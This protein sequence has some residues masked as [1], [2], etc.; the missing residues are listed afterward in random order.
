[1]S[2]LCILSLSI[3]ESRF[4]KQKD[5]VFIYRVEFAGKYYAD[6]V[7]KDKILL[8]LKSVKTLL[9]I[10]R[11]QTI[12]YLRLSKLRVGFLINFYNPKTEFERCFY[13]L[14]YNILR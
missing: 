13:D 1:M 2:L 9:P 8:E 5:F 10:M 6:I 12:N 7:V 11:A 4:E 14:D 3:G